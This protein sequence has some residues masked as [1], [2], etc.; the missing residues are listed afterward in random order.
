LPELTVAKGL[1]LNKKRRRMYT[2]VRAIKPVIYSDDCARPGI[3]VNIPVQLA[4][5][6][7]GRSIHDQRDVRAA[8]CGNR[9]GAV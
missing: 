8:G 2:P 3:G 5:E 9:R 1:I 6:V 4:G 7:R